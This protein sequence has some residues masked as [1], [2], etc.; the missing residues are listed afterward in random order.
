[1]PRSKW[2]GPWR[3]DREAGVWRRRF[4]NPLVQAMQLA[5]NTANGYAPLTA[6]AM[7]FV[8]FVAHYKEVVVPLKS[9]GRV[10]PDEE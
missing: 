8:G 9:A 10:S 3:L 2:E 6:P 4:R 1:M 5:P 7:A